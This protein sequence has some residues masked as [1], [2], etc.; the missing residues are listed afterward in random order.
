MRRTTGRAAAL[1]AAVIASAACAAPAP[2]AAALFSVGGRIGIANY[3]GDVLYKSG[4]VGDDL[5]IG[6]HAQIALLPKIA[7]EGAAEYFATTF[8][9]DASFEGFTFSREVDFRDIALYATA[10]VSLGLLPVVPL[11]PYVGVGPDLHI[12]ST[13]VVRET[14]D[15]PAADE[16][17]EKILEDASRG[18]FHVVAGLDAGGFLV[19]IGVFVEGRYSRIGSDPKI[20]TTS[21][22]AGFRFGF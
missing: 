6:A 2:A 4:D 22:L 21:A 13:E 1:M 20:S 12:L 3:S 11:H 14:F 15:D 17:P 5:V 10:K 7:L 9:Y 8:E 18:G 19:P 16:P